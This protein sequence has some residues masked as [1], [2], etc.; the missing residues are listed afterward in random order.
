M[1]CLWLSL[2]DAGKPGN[3]SASGIGFKA[4][5]SAFDHGKRWL[6]SAQTVIAAEQASMVVPLV[7][8]GAKTPQL[9]P[10]DLAYYHFI[11][12]VATPSNPSIEQVSRRT[13]ELSHARLSQSDAAALVSALTG[14]SE[15]LDRISIGR[16]Q[17]NTTPER[18][19]SLEVLKLRE[20]QVLEAARARVQT[21][22]TASGLARL[23]S[24]IQE[25]VKRNIVIYEM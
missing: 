14:V 24:H 9:V 3:A 5:S 8:D 2:L 20:A 1:F 19:D 12:A 18:N 22:L 10:D 25:H 17:H 23:E 15:E 6:N 7:V 13:R 21:S 11:L 16:Q 4:E